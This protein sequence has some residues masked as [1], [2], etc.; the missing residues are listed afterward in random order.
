MRKLVITCFSLLILNSL[1]ICYAN[2]NA[3]KTIETLYQNAP[4]SLKITDRIYWFSGQLL[5]MPYKL[6][7]LGEGDNGHYDQSPLYRF[8]AFDC[9]TYV[10]T[11]LALSMSSTPKDFKHNLNTIRYADSKPAYLA[12]NHFMSLDWQPNNHRKGLLTDIT[13][14]IQ[15]NNGA[16]ICQ[17]ATAQIDKAGWLIKKPITDIKLQDESLQSTRRQE[18]K[19]K[20]PKYQPQEATINYLP[21]TTL[22]PEGK[23]D[24]TLFSQIPSG[25]M[26]TIVRPNWQLKDL[27]GTNLNVSHVG[28]AIKEGGKLYFR[29]ASQIKKEVSDTLLM[30][31]LKR[32]L[33]SPTIKGINVIQFNTVILN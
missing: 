2:S 4:P 33:N 15:S 16:S 24:I 22:F 18:L 6:G 7:P 31:Y 29:E 32:Y 30:D 23:A 20:A 9:L 14:R 5:G 27:I 12:R 8:D 25:S 1:T 19:A 10:E 17:I 11:V 13:C 26:I 3:D 28:L 21:L